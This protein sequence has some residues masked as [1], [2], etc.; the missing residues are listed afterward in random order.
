VSAINT[1]TRDA[2][3]AIANDLSKQR[4][5]PG[6]EVRVEAGRKH[7]GKTGRVLRHQCDKFGS[8]FRY[9][10]D[11]NLHMRE[12]AGRYGFVVLVATETEQFWVKAEYVRCIDD[13]GIGTAALYLDKQALYLDELA[14]P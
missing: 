13:M 6:R 1:E 14:T 12:M 9:G 10:G 7:R 2:W 11:A 4:P 5:Y 3:Q 8:A